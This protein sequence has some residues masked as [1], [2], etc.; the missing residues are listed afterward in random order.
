MRVKSLTKE[1]E[2][3]W[4]ATFE[5]DGF[6][7]EKRIKVSGCARKVTA[8]IKRELT[9]LFLKVC[10]E[11]DRD[12]AYLRHGDAWREHIEY[13]DNFWRPDGCPPLTWE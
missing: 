9:Y 13:K 11:A 7:K 2:N 6:E 5:R 8:N 4:V 1:D 3:E 10:R 12:L